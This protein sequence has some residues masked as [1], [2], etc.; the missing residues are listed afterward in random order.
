MAVIHEDVPLPGETSEQILNRLLATELG[1]GGVLAQRARN[2]SEDLLYA[3]VKQAKRREEKVEAAL[4]V[5]ESAFAEG[6]NRSGAKATQDEVSLL[7]E[8]VRKAM[9]FA[10]TVPGLDAQVVRANHTV[11]APQA[12]ANPEFNGVR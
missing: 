9:A 5:P 6:F 4:L 10:A 1:L 8:I 2:P 3:G 12:D 7:D 11:P